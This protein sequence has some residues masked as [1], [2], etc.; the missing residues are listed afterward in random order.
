MSPLPDYFDLDKYAI[1]PV[2]V[3]RLLLRCEPEEI[4][5]N[6]V[7][8]PIWYRHLTAIHGRR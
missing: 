7:I 2:D 4:R 3:A 1:S 8:T 6:V 5:E